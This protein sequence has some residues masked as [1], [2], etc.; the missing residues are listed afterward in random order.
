MR[1]VGLFPFFLSVVVRPLG[2]E[3]MI[4]GRV[5]VLNVVYKKRSIRGILE[6]G[7]YLRMVSHENLKDIVVSLLAGD[8]EKVKG[9]DR[10]TLRSNSKGRYFM[11][12]SYF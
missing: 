6:H 3:V 8:V 11:R 5:S 1:A 9:L 7:S 2:Y 10:F 12:E 4:L